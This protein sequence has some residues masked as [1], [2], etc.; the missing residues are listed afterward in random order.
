MPTFDL[1][2]PVMVAAFVAVL[3]LVEGLYLLVRDL[4]GGSAAINRRLRMLAAGKDGKAV[5]DSLRRHR[6]GDQDKLAGRLLQW[7]PAGA[8]D[9]MIQEVGLLTTTGRFLLRMGAMTMATGLA[10]LFALHL[11]PMAAAALALAVGIGLPLLWLRRRAAARLRKLGEQLPDA[12]DMIVRSLRAGHPVATAIGNVGREMPD[13]IGTEFGLVFDEMTYGLDLR[14]ALENLA[15]RV[16]V[17]DLRFLVV[18]VRVQ[19]GTGGNLAEVLGNL[20][21]VVRERM[22]MKRKVHALSAE[23]R[24]SATILSALPFVLAGLIFLLRPAYYADS[25]DD[26]LFL[27]LLASGIAGILAGI[28]VM[29]RIVN[30][31][32]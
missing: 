22:T 18:A 3:L 27:P 15:A 17:S 24:L 12:V 10:G 20:S 4:T 11:T 1:P 6:R 13:P 23:G 29:Q 2:F 5:L 25:T 9:R 26:P 31:R 8:L 19:Y 16:A 21:R 32:I 7:G 30:F 28:V 14:E